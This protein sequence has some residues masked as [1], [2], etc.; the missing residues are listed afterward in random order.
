MTITSV[1]NV[2]FEAVMQRKMQV[3]QE[4]WALV[5]Y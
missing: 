1:D 4:L 3:V 2:M 5:K